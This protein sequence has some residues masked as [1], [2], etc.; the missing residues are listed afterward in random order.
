MQTSMELGMAAHVSNIFGH[1]IFILREMFE[2]KKCSLS[3][4]SPK[5]DEKWR[6]IVARQ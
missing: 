4:K 5:N 6:K 3:K 1:Y 2:V